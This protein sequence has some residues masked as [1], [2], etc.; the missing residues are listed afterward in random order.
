MLKAELSL[1]GLIWN[2]LRSVCFAQH[3]TKPAHS[4]QQEKQSRSGKQCDINNINM[5]GQKCS[6][7]V[8]QDWA[9]A[10]LAYMTQHMCS[11]V[12]ISM[13]AKHTLSLLDW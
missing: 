12:H 2:A 13:Q 8:R 3:C 7:K 4:G 9:V 11:L 1:R 10:M 5:T 6:A